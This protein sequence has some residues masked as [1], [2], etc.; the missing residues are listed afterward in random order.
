M[1]GDVSGTT[2]QT[3]NAGDQITFAEYGGIFNFRTLST[4]ENSL[5]TQIRPAGLEIFRNGYLK[6]DAYY[7]KVIT[8]PYPGS[9]VG[10]GRW[11]V[12]LWQTSAG[13]TFSGGKIRVGGNWSWAN[14][15]GHIEIDYG[16]YVA[17]GSTTINSGSTRFSSGVAGAYDNLRI[18]DIEVVDGYAGF[19]V[20]SSNSNNPYVHFDIYCTREPLF[21]STSWESNALPTQ[22]GVEFEKDVHIDGN[23]GIGTTSPGSKLDVVGAISSTSNISG[24]SGRLVLRDNS[25]ENH[26]TNANSNVAINYVGYAGGITQFRDLDIYNGKGGFIAQFDGSSSRV[27]IGISSPTQK[28]DVDGNIK[29][30]GELYSGSN[31]VWHAG[32]LTFTVSGS[33]DEVLTITTS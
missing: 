11:F 5:N 6:Q 30:S 19:Y 7:K 16:V 15:M 8:L 24:T 1:R 23:L 3:V 10:A 25:L 21:E 22:R 26:F 14:I 20:W 13:A 2:T 31:K 29:A 4:T 12:R 18:G 17:S 33:N 28:L 32:N 9:N 27:G